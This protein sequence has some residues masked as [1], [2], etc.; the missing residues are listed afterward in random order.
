MSLS[1]A[2]SRL[3]NQCTEAYDS[4]IA[5]VG[6]IRAGTAQ[7][8]DSLRA[9]HEAM[10]ASTRQHLDDA[11]DAVR[12]DVAAL[13]HSRNAERQAMHADQRARLD[14]FRSDL[15]ST[16]ETLTS[17]NNAER[18]A[19]SADQRARL[20]GFMA[21]LRHTVTTFVGDSNAERQAMHADQRAHLDGFMSDLR[22]LVATF[23]GDSSAE[24]QAMHAD[25]RAGLD[26]AMN[27]LKLNVEAFRAEATAERNRIHADHVGAQQSWAQFSAA[28]QQRRGGKT[29]PA[30]AAQP[31]QGEASPA[32]TAP[33]PD[34]L[35]VIRGIGNGMQGRLNTAGI[36]TFADLAGSTPDQLRAALA[37]AGRLA[38]VEE[39]IV[40]ARTFTNQP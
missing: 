4:R 15:R 7:Q 37:E 6:S 32:P 29:Q 3:T 9:A 39:W 14:T 2:M 5:A 1:D 13:L 28:M 36:F 20:D 16:V 21:D 17:S 34:D 35:T 23:I 27:Q 18:Q 38:N 40:E 11:S 19:M 33:A 22:S 24:R 25:Q 31:A 30:A 8:I 26:Q 10:A 12:H